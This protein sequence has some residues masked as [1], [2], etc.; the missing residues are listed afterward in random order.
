[1]D[2]SN[3]GLAT[4]HLAAADERRV[5]ELQFVRR[6]HR[7][8]ML[9]TVLCA[10][11][12]A[13]VLDERAAGWPAW[14]LLA[15]N[16]LLWPQLANLYSRRA[17]G[18]ATA[19]FRCLLL[20][21][22]ASGAW[23]AAMALA[24]APSALFLT[25]AIAD[26][27]AAGGWRLVR[28]A[29]VAMV[30][31]FLAVWGLLGLPFQPLTSHRT[32]LLCGPFLFVYT[33]SLSLIADRLGNRI[34]VQN[35]ELERRSRT[36]PA[37]QMPN[38]PHFE[39]VAAQ[40]LSHFHR[41][42]RATVL[43]LLDVDNFKSINDR[44]G[45]VT[46]D[47][48]LK[49]VATLLRESVR[50]TDLSAR[51]GGDEFALLLVD[52]ALPQAVEVAERIHRDAAALRFAEPGLSCT[53]SIGVAAAKPGIATLDAWV[54]VADAALYRAKAAGRNRVVQAP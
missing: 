1:M 3:P 31:A 34:R 16:A 21:S 46:G 4:P 2:S 28:R 52:T 40:E 26:K 20:D 29:S 38:R 43:V 50:D 45:H 19:Q 42:Q 12:I 14:L 53:L 44:Y 51:W 49:R 35:R 9:G 27:I 39:S 7:M 23:I 24:A 6:V 10:L 22:A 25:M 15:L 47:A 32:L 37:M 18:P 17:R 41:S 30:L 54:R 36:D 5:R 13:S 33:V 11:P 8:R 48:V